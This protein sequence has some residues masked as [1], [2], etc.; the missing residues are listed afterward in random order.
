MLGNLTVRD[1]VLLEKIAW[2]RE[3]QLIKAEERAERLR[4][5]RRWCL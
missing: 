3:Q 1:Q 4:Q 2:H 5:A